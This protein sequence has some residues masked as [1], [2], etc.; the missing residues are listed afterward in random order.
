[1]SSNSLADWFEKF[2]RGAISRRE[3]VERAAYGGL[4][5]SVTTA[6]LGLQ[7]SQS[8]AAEAND[9]THAHDHDHAAEHVGHADDPDQTNVN[10]YEEWLKS[11]G[12][13]VHRGYAIA[14]LRALE[15]APWR[16]LG[17]RGAHIELVGG[18]GVNQAYV[19][20][21]APGESTNP[22]RYLFE[23]VVYVLSGEGESTIWTPKT[24]KQTVRWNAGSILGPPLNAW[25]QHANR[26]REPARLLVVTNAPVVLDLFHN[27]DFVF[28][29]DF[30]F[31]DRYDGEPDFF[32]AGP[33]K[34]RR[35][36]TSS[37]DSE[38]KGGVYS[39]LG[40]Y[41]PDARSIGL[42]VTTE[43]GAGNS[44]IELQ[45]ADNTMQAHLSEF[46]V[47][48]YKKAHRHGPGSH[49]AMLNGRGYTLMWKGALRYS[50]A[51][52]KV[53]IEF[54][55]ASLFVPPDGW[56]HQHF[57]TGPEPARYLAA[58]WG[59][60]GRWFMRGLGGGGRTHRLG[61]TS[62]RRG[63]N[64][65]EYDDEDPTIVAMFADEL[66][67]SGVPMKMPSRKDK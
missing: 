21:L 32:G 28:N 67:K 48:T 30:V 53:R 9:D 61:K 50:E 66:K 49:V 5:L 62:T 37:R 18:E 33:D 6:A 8:K 56:F 10:P 60:D 38:I 40:A 14:D 3:F 36:A 64:L 2:R 24:A 17:G 25:R 42:A 34:L 11:E 51:P 12:I 45:M 27:A 13:P 4:S 15:L 65:I 19:C 54:T 1:M 59:G 58:T 43:R 63:G 16:R 29:N 55:E 46:A 39:W 44:R 57:N 35:K 52:T 26:G 7:R 47:G 41:V 31:R 23:E 20:E 22:Q